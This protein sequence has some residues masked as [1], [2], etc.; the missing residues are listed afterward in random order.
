MSR[1]EGLHGPCATHEVPR[2]APRSAVLEYARPPRRHDT[3]GKAQEACALPCQ[4][5]TSPT[6]YSLLDGTSRPEEIA[7]TAKQLGLT[8]LAITDHDSLSCAYEFATALKHHGTQPITGVKLTPADGSDMTLLAETHTGYG[9]LSQLVT[10]SKHGNPPAAVSLDDAPRTWSAT[11]LGAYVEGLILLTGCRE[12]QLAR[13]V[14]ADKL[15]KAEDIRQTSLDRNRAAG[16]LISPVSA[17]AM[18]RRRVPQPTCF[19]ACR[20][21]SRRA[22]GWLPPCVHRGGR[23]RRDD[24]RSYPRGRRVAGTTIPQR[25]VCLLVAN[26][27]PRHHRHAVRRHRDLG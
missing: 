19:A 15:A 9:N 13:L 23:R 17:A 27:F 22:S 8:S 14:T 24:C 26:R 2:G 5:E 18:I 21:P 20:Q 11:S 1:W 7:L 4:A 16:M 12:S 3:E 10:E 6:P 25:H